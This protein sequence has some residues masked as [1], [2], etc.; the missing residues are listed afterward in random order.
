[1]PAGLNTWDNVIEQM[2]SELRAREPRADAYW[3]QQLAFAPVVFH[4]LATYARARGIPEADAPNLS[5]VLELAAA[6]LGL[7]PE[8]GTDPAALAAIA[9]RQAAALATG[10]RRQLARL[11]Q[12][13]G[14][15]AAVGVAKEVPS[16]LVRPYPL[17]GWKPA[18]P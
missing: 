11:V 17:L 6:A 14:L 4:A 15:T 13:H 10:R 16:R 9:R 3:A 1:M 12:R 7:L 8:V 18:S 5:R 2:L